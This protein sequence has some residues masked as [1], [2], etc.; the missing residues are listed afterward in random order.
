MRRGARARRACL[1][2]HGVQV[3]HPLEVLYNDIGARRA[4]S[5][6]RSRQWT[7]RPDRLLLRL[8]DRAALRRRSTTRTTRPR[9]DE[10][11]RGRRRA[12]GGLPAARPSAAAASLTG[13]MPE[14]GVRLNY[15]LLKEAARK[16]RRGDRHDLP[17]L[18]VQ[19]GRVPGRDRASRSASAL[20]MPV[21]YFT[22]VLGW[23]L[24]GELRRSSGCT[25]SIV[26]RRTRLRRWF[27][28]HEGGRG[29][30]LT[31][32]GA[33]R[34]GVYVCHCGT[35]IAGDRWTCKAV[36]EYAAD[37]ARTWWSRA[38]TS[39]CARI[40]GQELI[41]QDIREHKL[42][43]IV[44]ASCSPLLHEQTFR[45]ATAG[46]RAEP[47]LLPDGQHPRARLLGAHRPRQRRPRRPRTWSRAA[48]R[49]V[50]LPQGARRRAACRSTPTCWSSAAAS[51]A[52]TRR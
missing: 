19:P 13:T 27:A 36:A 47:V 24:G 37:A 48:V 52:S 26:G 7:R 32:T 28:A 9:M 21:L 23:A 25:R 38:T 22:Q 45:T 43:R 4:S 8:P 1:R 31:R 12:D 44:V 46:G 49:R 5:A 15:I 50:A 33:V 40:P 3:R 20:D 41:Q 42:N 35:N 6:G 17:A 51:P 10:L 39:T 2:R 14:V 29:L 34:I 16:R 18:P 11:L 30:C